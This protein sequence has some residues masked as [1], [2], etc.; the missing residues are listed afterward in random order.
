MK[1]YVPL[2]HISCDSEIQQRLCISF[3]FSC[4]DLHL[5]CEEMVFS[6][7]WTEMVAIKLKQIAYHIFKQNLHKIFIINNDDN[8][9]FMNQ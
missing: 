6:S 3:A 4:V 2:T 1:M 8:N 9:A 7:L 5:E